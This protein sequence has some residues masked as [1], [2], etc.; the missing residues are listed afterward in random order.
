MILFLKHIAIE[1][2]ETLGR[3]LEGKGFDI[4]ILELQ[5]GDS[6]PQNL[7]DVEAVVSL[8]GP[9]NVYEEDKHPFLKQEN[10]F[11][12]KVLEKE[13][14]FIG[15]CLGSQLLA[16]ACGAK[17]RESPKKEIGFFSVQ[18]TP[19][20][21]K[22]PL[23]A[24]LSENLDVYQ[25]HED[26]WELPSEATLLASSGACPHQAFRVGANAYGLQFH[27]EI[28]DVSIKEWAQAYFPPDDSSC[29]KQKSNQSK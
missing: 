6:L 29:E 28:T 7:D 17:V 9:M 23:F 22:D 10:V 15:L 5:D 14:P 18:L 27:V 12:K 25:W 16:K 2:P 11:L 19:E 1:G 4:K 24:G 8:G 20:G 3:F 13:I 21:K 26:M